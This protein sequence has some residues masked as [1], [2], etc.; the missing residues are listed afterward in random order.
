MQRTPLAICS[1]TDEGAEVTDPKQPDPENEDLDLDADV[2][3]DLEPQGDSTDAVRGGN[4][5]CP[6]RSNDPT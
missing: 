1:A 5:G 4:V 2:V 3:T 6:R